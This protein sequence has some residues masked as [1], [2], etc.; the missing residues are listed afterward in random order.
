MSA[1]ERTLKYHLVWYRIVARGAAAGGLCNGRVS[2]RPS[3]RLSH[4]LTVAAACGAVAVLGM[5]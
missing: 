1:F 5:G 4:L 2:V 3:V